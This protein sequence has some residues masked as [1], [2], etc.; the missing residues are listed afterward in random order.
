MIYLEAPNYHA[1]G[2]LSIKNGDGNKSIFLAGMISGAADWQG[3][4]A[5]VLLPHFNVFNPRRK[6]YNNLIPDEEHNQIAWE[7]FYLNL[8]DI[9]LFNFR[10]E[11]VG[12][13][14]LFEYGKMLE[15][16]KRTWQKLYVCVDKNY[17]RKNDIYIQTELENP[18]LA[19]NIFDNVDKMC[20]A[21]IQENK[22]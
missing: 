16:T 6:M 9:V 18:Q 17:Q 12:P 3:N 15:K 2:Q 21:I 8:A 5:K 20:E 4:A 7:H 22:I 11:T 19:K 1:P 10:P 14:T 13:I